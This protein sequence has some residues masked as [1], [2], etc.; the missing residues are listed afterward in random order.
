[1]IDKLQRAW[2]LAAE[3][4]EGQR[5]FT[6]QKGV[7]LPYLTHLGAVMLEAQEA[8]R[9]NPDLDQ[10]LMLLCAILH[11]SLEDTDLPAAVIKA[12]F[13]DRVLAGV[14]ALTKD[15]SLP[16]KPEQMADS[17]RRIKQQ[18][19]EVAAVKLCDRINNLSPPPN[20]WTAAKKVAYRNEAT[21]IL[22]ELGSADDYLAKRLQEKIDA[23]PI[24]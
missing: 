8:L 9:H 17:L 24:E 18:P 15:E 1:M 22:K 10:E 5:Y 6:P 7:T 20:H 4:H 11:D 23:Y 3:H 13:G 2:L 14:R 12:E 19:R 16:S 21:L